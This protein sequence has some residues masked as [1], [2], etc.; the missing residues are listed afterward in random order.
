MS[1]IKAILKSEPSE[2]SFD[3]LVREGRTVWSGIHNFV[4]LKNLEALRVGDAVGIYHTGSERAVVGIAIVTRAAYRPAGE[5]HSKFRVVDLRAGRRFSRP[6][7]LEEIKTDSAFQESLLV[8]MGRVSVVPL[9]P[10]QSDA[11]DRLSR[12]AAPPAVARGADP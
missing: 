10:E 8:T 5:P 11:L 12:T 9:T 3:D 4:A 2:Y 7:P 6:V 1:A